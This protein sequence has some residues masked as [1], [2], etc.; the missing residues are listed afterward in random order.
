LAIGGA[1]VAFHSSDESAA[2]ADLSSMVTA[3][4]ESGSFV[5]E[6]IESGEVESSSNVEI[7]C[8]VDTSSA[9]IAILE[10]VPEGT[11]VNEGDF[12]VRLND[13]GLQ[14]QLV[15]R[16]IDVN[17]SK[18][19]LAQAKADLEGAKL[20]LQEYESG[21]F[22]EREEQLE[23]DEFVARE[24]LRRAEEYLRY[25]EKLAEKGYVSQVQLEADR[26][27]VEKAK[28]ELDVTRTKLEVLRTYTREKMIN[29]LEANIETSMARLSSTERSYEIDQRQLR[30]VQDQ[31]EKCTIYAPTSGQVVYANKI[32]SSEEPLIEEGKMVRERQ[33]IIRL[34]DPKR[35]QTVAAVNES[36]IDSIEEGMPV[37]IRIDALPDVQLK[38]TLSKVSEFPMPR[39]NSYTAHIK[40]YAATITIHDPPEALRPGMTAEVA[41][42]V[43]RQDDVLM[44]PV[45]AVVERK[46][47]FFCLVNREEKELEPREI[48]VGGANDKVVLVNAGLEGGENVVLGPEPYIDEMPLPDPSELAERKAEKEAYVAR[49]QQEG[50]S[51]ITDRS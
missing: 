37:R 15:T 13:A 19:K 44:V 9:G 42:L 51:E 31:I 23:G 1:A 28:K 50:S 26:F 45:H 11:Y 16:Q 18:A 7:R 35:M 27:A 38:G 39:K 48:E 4:V 12:L 17:M 34:P 46:E 5:D 8:E 14:Q 41:I 25:S 3:P 43:D 24:N 32:N 21:T 47:R 6:I 33:E 29:E 22:R 30:E 36:R 20:A 2:G 40:N 49:E 10:I